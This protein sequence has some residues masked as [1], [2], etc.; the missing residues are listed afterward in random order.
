MHR[1][2]VSLIPYSPLAFGLLTGKYDESGTDGPATPRD[3]RIGKFESVRKQRW[4]RPE[5]L[6]AA[7][8]YNA[9]ARAAGLTP[10]KMAL[11]WSYTNWRVASTIIGV[12]TVAQLDEDLDAWGTKL[13]SELLAE[14]DKIRWEIRDPAV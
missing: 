2:N 6:A 1:L 5:S 3:A 7:R 4:G 8:R 10:T 13:P 9:L 14:I 11:A 12:R